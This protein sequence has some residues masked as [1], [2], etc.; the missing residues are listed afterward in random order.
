M[1]RILVIE[2]DESLRRV[3]QAQLQRMGHST[4]SAADAW[5]A[6]ELLRKEPQDFVICDLNLPDKTG[7][8]VLKEARD[9]IPRDHGRYRNRLRHHRNSY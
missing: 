1:G 2:D 4:W 9:S 7:I 6:L 3:M 8:E 5:R